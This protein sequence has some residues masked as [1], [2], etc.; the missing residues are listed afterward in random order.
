MESS[1]IIA[2]KNFIS[3]KYA[4]RLSGYT[5]DYIGQ[6]AREGRI[7]SEMVGRRRFVCEEDLINYRRVE[8]EAKEAIKRERNEKL[9]KEK[10]SVTPVP[11]KVIRDNVIPHERVKAD[12]LDNKDI[13][14]PVLHHGEHFL[15]PYYESRDSSTVLRRKNTRKER[16][17]NVTPR[18]SKP[19]NRSNRIGVAIVVSALI[20]TALLI[21]GLVFFNSQHLDVATVADTNTATEQIASV[22]SAQDGFLSRIAKS[23]YVSL[24]NLM[25][26]VMGRFALRTHEVERVHVVYTY[27][28]DPVASQLLPSGKNNEGLVVFPSV[29]QDVD[30]EEIRR[31]KQAFSDEVIVQPGESGNSGIVRPIFRQEEGRDFMYVLVPVDPPL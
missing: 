24:S 25:S 23:V 2:E 14:G 28:E 13:A 19:Q 6:I 31:I 5:S 20:P 1:L 16:V 18:L 8:L 29:S 7:R 3:T 15:S 30:D 27:K 12:R 10:K 4:S 17:T 22:Y 9:E 26:P 21:G 11:I